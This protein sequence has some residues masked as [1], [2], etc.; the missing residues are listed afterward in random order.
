MV[1]CIISKNFTTCFLL[2][3]EPICSEPFLTLRP[4]KLNDRHRRRRNDRKFRLIV[5]TSFL[6]FVAFEVFVFE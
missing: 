4:L 6:R 5:S 1:D 2:K 3:T